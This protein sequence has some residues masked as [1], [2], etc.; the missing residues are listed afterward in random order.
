MNYSPTF[1]TGLLLIGIYTAQI[2]TNIN[3]T[4]KTRNLL[5]FIALTLF[6]AIINLLFGDRIAAYTL[7]VGILAWILSVFLTPSETSILPIIPRCSSSAPPPIMYIEPTYE[8]EQ[9]DGTSDTIDCIDL[10]L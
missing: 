2:Y 7:G 3:N 4:N 10:K 8:C 6:M 1:I 5:Y 9:C